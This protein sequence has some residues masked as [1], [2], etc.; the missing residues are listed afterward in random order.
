MTR[1]GAAVARSHSFPSCAPNHVIRSL[2]CDRPA[3]CLC[4]ISG[5]CSRLCVCLYTAHSEC[6]GS[7]CDPL[8]DSCQHFH[9]ACVMDVK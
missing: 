8:L 6:G 3:L 7:N 2:R 1:P 5:F 9:L 4:P